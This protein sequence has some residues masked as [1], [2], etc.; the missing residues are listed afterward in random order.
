MSPSCIDKPEHQLFDVIAGL[1]KVTTEELSA[2]NHIEK[3]AQQE[4]VGLMM[5]YFEILDVT[6]EVEPNSPKKLIHIVIALT[7]NVCGFK[8]SRTELGLRNPKAQLR[9]LAS[10]HLGQVQFQKI[11]QLRGHDPCTN[12]KTSKT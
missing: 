1:A 8:N 12:E 2:M 9:F 7:R 6:T 10:L 4:T 11:L 5:V 3:Y